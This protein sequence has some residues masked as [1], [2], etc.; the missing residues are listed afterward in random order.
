MYIQESKQEVTKVVSLMKRLKHTRCTQLP[1]NTHS[2]VKTLIRKLD[3]EETTDEKRKQLSNCANP[4]A[5][6]SLR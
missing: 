2:I 1:F 4:R 6:L 5:I 3:N